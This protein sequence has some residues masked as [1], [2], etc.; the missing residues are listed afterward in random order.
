MAT[1]LPAFGTED[2]SPQS[3]YVYRLCFSPFG[4][5]QRGE[6][7]PRVPWRT[8]Q[9]SSLYQPG[10]LASRNQSNVA[11]PPAPNDDSLLLIDYLIENTGQIF[12]EAG[13]CRFRRHIVIVQ[14]SCTYP[15]R[16]PRS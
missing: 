13:V 10:E 3:G 8:E 15:S 6:Q 5:V 4:P 12:T 7:T 14:G 16:A 9:V 2:L 1:R 11:R